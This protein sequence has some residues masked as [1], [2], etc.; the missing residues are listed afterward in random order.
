MI[1]LVKV[2]K[3]QK[4][5]LKSSLKNLHISIHDSSKYPNISKEVSFYFLSYF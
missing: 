4:K 2:N 3:I 5:N 1:L